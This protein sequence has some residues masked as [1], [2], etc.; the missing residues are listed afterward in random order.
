M[1]RDEQDDTCANEV[2]AIHQNQP[3]R[4]ALHSAI[5]KKAA[6]EPPMSFRIV[7]MAV[8]DVRAET[9]NACV[10]H[11]V[12]LVLPCGAQSSFGL[13]L[14]IFHCAAFPAA[15]STTRRSLLMRHAAAAVPAYL[16]TAARDHRKATRNC[17]SVRKTLRSPP[18][19]RIICLMAGS[20]CGALVVNTCCKVPLRC[21]HRVHGTAAMPIRRLLQRSKLRTGEI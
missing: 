1:A 11:A 12:E 5:G 4:R 14:N 16:P 8:R 17:S 3:P 15:S 13:G 2:D 20:F 9:T 21:S 10:I 6:L 18:P 19:F 7:E